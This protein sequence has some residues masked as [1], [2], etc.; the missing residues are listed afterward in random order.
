MNGGCAIRG[1]HRRA[2]VDANAADCG[3]DPYAARCKRI[4]GQGVENTGVVVQELVGVRSVQQI[5]DLL[6]LVVTQAAVAG[7]G[8]VAA[9]GDGNRPL[10]HPLEDTA[11]LGG[12]PSHM[13]GAAGHRIIEHDGVDDGAVQ[14][15]LVQTPLDVVALDVQFHGEGFQKRIQDSQ[16]HV[17]I[18]G[19]LRGKQQADHIS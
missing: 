7:G 17:Q 4:I 13:A 10:H 19:L 1:H 16:H 3:S 9:L 18:A 5:M 6:V 11:V 14:D 8:A 2:A 15:D 12:K